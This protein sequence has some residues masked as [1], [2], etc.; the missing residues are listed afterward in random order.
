M[1]NY[2][3]KLKGIILSIC[4]FFL[5]NMYLIF[6]LTK[7]VTDKTTGYLIILISNEIFIFIGGL[8]YLIYEFKLK[9][10][11]KITELEYILKKK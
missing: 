8:F 2:W 10:N 5:S 11:D 6:I 3:F 7:Y 4:V 1:L 9:Y